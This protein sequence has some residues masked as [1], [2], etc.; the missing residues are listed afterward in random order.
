[1]QRPQPTNDD[2]HRFPEPRRA[3][4][5]TVQ[6]RRSTPAI[7]DRVSFQ[8]QPVRRLRPIGSQIGRFPRQNID[9]V[10]SQSQLVGQPESRVPGLQ[11]RPNNW[12]YR[13]SQ[14]NSISTSE[15]TSSNLSQRQHQSQW[16]D[17]PVQRLSKRVRHEPGPSGQKS[18]N[19]RRISSTLAENAIPPT[20]PTQGSIAAVSVAVPPSTTPPPGAQIPLPSN[21]PII[22]AR[23]STR[24]KS[25]AK[26]AISDDQTTIE[27]A[28]AVKT[29]L[30]SWVLMEAPFPNADQWQAAC[31]LFWRQ[32]N[33][34]FFISPPI[35]LVTGGGPNR[36]ITWVISS[37]QDMISTDFVTAPAG[38]R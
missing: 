37:I 33:E 15:A 32:A 29:R 2:N 7:S 11:P 38:M 9:R 10:D 17:T 16:P 1:M 31:L 14:A 34:Q 5:Q 28:Q 30:Q 4:S 12:E 18:S 24:R 27:I 35:S 21:I 22:V 23:A 25:R 19:Q 13:E 36:V 3:A 26:E 6:P 20:P 8:S